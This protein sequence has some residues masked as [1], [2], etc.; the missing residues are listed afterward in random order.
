MFVRY[1]PDRKANADSGKEGGKGVMEIADRFTMIACAFDDLPGK[2][3]ACMALGLK[4]FVTSDSVATCYLYVFFDEAGLRNYLMGYYD[5][6]EE[7]EE[8]DAPQA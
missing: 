1:R 8:C 2:L 6:R 7:S 5:D 4:F 3:R